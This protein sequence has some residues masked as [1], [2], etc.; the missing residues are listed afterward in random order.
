[1]AKPA[2][3]KSMCQWFFLVQDFAV[4]TISMEMVPP[5]YFCFGEKLAS[6]K[7]ATK[8][9]K[10]KMG[11]VSFF[12]VKLQEEAKKTE[13]LP[14]FQRWKKKTNILQAS[15][16]ILKIRKLLRRN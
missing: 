12:M 7:F 5:V 8:T 9:A 15:F 16:I 11:I 13:I 1:M 3:G 6:S 14:R 10:K 2:L 4:Q